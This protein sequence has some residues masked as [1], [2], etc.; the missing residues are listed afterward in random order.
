MQYFSRFKQGFASHGKRQ[1]FYVLVLGVKTAKYVFHLKIR[2]IMYL[3][4]F[5]RCFFGIII[6]SVI[7]HTTLIQVFVVCFY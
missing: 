3:Y 1:N 6:T 7:G 5:V 4:C 2:H